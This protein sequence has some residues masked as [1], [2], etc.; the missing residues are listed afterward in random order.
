M[1]IHKERLAVAMV[2]VPRPEDYFQRTKKSLEDTGFF[3]CERDLPLRLIAGWPDTSHI[4]DLKGDPKRFLIDP[5]GQAEAKEFHFDTLGVKP[6]CAFGHFRAMRNLLADTAWS[7]G[8]ILE[9]DI[10][11]SKGWRAYLD[12]LVPEI[13]KVHGERWMLSLYR[14]GDCHQKGA[15]AEFQK[16]KSWFEPDKTIP[17]W[18]TQ[19]IV[20]TREALE[21][22]PESLLERCMKTFIEPVDIT[23]GEYA[24]EH[25]IAVLVSLPSLVQHIGIKT[26]GQSEWFHRAECFQDS[27]E[28]LIKPEDQRTG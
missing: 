2:T 22:L 17:F 19:A 15:L 8:L 16:G 10:Q 9:D 1:S 20:Y 13:R 18:G 28:D 11:F 3:L 14:M 4:D 7:I 26:T 6:K 12:Y 21:V 24:K 27:V 5:L 25:G 23:L